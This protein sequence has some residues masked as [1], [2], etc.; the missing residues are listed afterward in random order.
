MNKIL[1]KRLMKMALPMIPGLM[2]SLVAWIVDFK[3]DTPL[4]PGE[5]HI[6]GVIHEEQ[7]QIFLYICAFKDFIVTRKIYTF[8]DSEILNIITNGLPDTE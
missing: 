3:K 5:T 1:E 8:K 7:E 2:D 6:G 4:L